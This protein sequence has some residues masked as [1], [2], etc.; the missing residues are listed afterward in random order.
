MRS[1][2]LQK[3]ASERL[4]LLVVWFDMLAGDG[5]QMTDRRLFSD[6]R[7]ANFWD[8]GRV[9]GRWFASNVD[10]YEGIAWDQ[11]YLYGADAQWADKPSPLLS[12]GGPLIGSRGDLEAALTPLLK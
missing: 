8:A 7:A 11:Y 4:R 1:E 9:V 10:G 12:E 3:H 5:R 2:I 6:P